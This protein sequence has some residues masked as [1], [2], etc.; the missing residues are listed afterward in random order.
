MK[1]ILAL[2]LA[3]AMCFS[4]TF[5][6]S[7]GAAAAR[8]EHK[9]ILKPCTRGGMAQLLYELAGSPAVSV[10]GMPFKDVPEDM[11]AAVMWASTHHYLN[12]MGETKYEPDE[13]ITRALIVRVLYYYYG[14]PEIKSEQP[15]FQDLEPNT[16]YYDAACWAVE[17]HCFDVSDDASR[18]HPHDSADHIIAEFDATPDGVQNLL[19]RTE[20]GHQWGPGTTVSPATCTKPE[21]VKSTCAICGFTGT[22]ENGAPLGHDWGEWVVIWEPSC[23]APGDKMRTCKRDHQHVEYGSIDPIGH[24]FGPWMVVEAATPEKDGIAVRYC[25]REESYAEY[26][27]YSYGELETTSFRDVDP[28]SYYYNPVL[29]ALSRNP[30]I[31]NGTGADTFSPDANCTRAQMVTFL[32]RAEGCPEPDEIEHSFT[33]LDETAYYYKAVLWAVEYEITKGTSATT[34]SPDAT[35]SRAQTV[36]FL[37]RTRGEPFVL[38]G[39]PFDD[40]ERD[41]YYTGAVKWAVQ[42]QITNGVKDRMFAPEAPCTRAQ[43]VTFLYRTLEA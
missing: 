25:L 12:G 28:Q 2:A 27:S 35:V 7:S 43:I 19:V 42:N 22:G 31:T 40:V 18:F 23:T 41:A 20:N 33:D 36:T 34:F 30:P 5:A 3:L 37:W 14:E 15:P 38:S 24:A 9:T 4:L 16:W 26:A 6:L 39:M 1:R 29:W 11:A 8:S 32:W 17:E 13:V 10:E 21:V